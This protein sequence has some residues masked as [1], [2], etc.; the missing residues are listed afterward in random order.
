M[1]GE[2]GSNTVRVALQAVK[3]SKDCIAHKENIQFNAAS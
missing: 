2:L 3:A 1:N